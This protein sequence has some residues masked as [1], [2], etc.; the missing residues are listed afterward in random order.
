M[1][2]NLFRCSHPAKYLFVEKS[3]DLIQKDEDFNELTV[4]LK[5]L[6]CLEPVTIKALTC[7]GGVEAFYARGDNNG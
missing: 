4:Y 7:I 5:C 6:Y 2:R 1:F 3:P